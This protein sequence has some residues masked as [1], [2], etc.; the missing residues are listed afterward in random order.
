[1]KS[2]Q[3]GVDKLVEVIGTSKR[4]SLDDATKKLGVSTQVV[5]EWAEFLER[6]KDGWVYDT[7]LTFSCK[8]N[9]CAH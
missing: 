9:A 7:K 6:E 5:Q 4:I 2:I 3:T 1:M 8:K